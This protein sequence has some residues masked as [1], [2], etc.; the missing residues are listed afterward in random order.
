MVRLQPCDIAKACATDRTVNSSG[1]RTRRA[2]ARPLSLKPLESSLKPP[3]R[4]IG[5]YD[6]MS[7]V[8]ADITPRGGRPARWTKLGKRQMEGGRCTGR[9]ASSHVGAELSRTL[10]VGR[11][12]AEMGGWRAGV[13]LA[14]DGGWLAPRRPVAV[15]KLRD[16][17]RRAT[18]GASRTT[19]RKQRDVGLTKRQRRSVGCAYRARLDAIRSRGRRAIECEVARMIRDISQEPLSGPGGLGMTFPLP[20][21]SSCPPPLTLA[22]TPSLLNS[23]SQSLSFPISL[24]KT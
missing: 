19:P 15:G 24:S 5:I 22:S 21:P 6:T 10:R 3:D 14:C 13:L 4:Q 2:P 20:S 1:W 11:A 16:S 18:A 7:N 8:G 12:P 9:V 23:L 17:Y